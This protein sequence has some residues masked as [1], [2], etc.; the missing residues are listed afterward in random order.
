[1][2]AVIKWAVDKGVDMV[3]SKWTSM[4]GMA[5]L[6]DAI[7]QVLYIFD[8]DTTTN[9]DYDKASR[10]V[11]EFCTSIGLFAAADTSAVKKE[12]KLA[13]EQQRRDADSGLA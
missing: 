2:N 3:R 7:I 1:M 9:F 4:A 13:M 12:T 10:A 6:I 5:L 11:V 8:T